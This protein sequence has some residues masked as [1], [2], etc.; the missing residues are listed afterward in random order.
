MF[1]LIHIISL[2]FI[3]IA[4]HAP[5][6]KKNKRYTILDTTIALDQYISQYQDS[7]VQS[8]NTINTLFEMAGH[9]A[10]INQNDSAFKYLKWAT[11]LDTDAL[12]FNYG[13]LYTLMQDKR[14]NTIEQTTFN[15]ALPKYKVNDT[16]TV[17]A[18]WRI[19]LIDQCYYTVI[20]FYE[21]KYSPEY[22]GHDSLWQL[23]LKAIQPNIQ[24]VTHLIDKIG[25]PKRS[26][27]TKK[28]SKAVFYALQHSNDS[29]ISHYLP[30]LAAACQ[31][32]EADWDDYAHMVD[33]ILVFNNHEQIYGTHYAYKSDTTNTVYLMPTKDTINLDKKRKILGLKPIKIHYKT[34]KIRFQSSKKK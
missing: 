28:G 12:L 10:I 7:L 18:L 17:K 14:W 11:E 20:H 4:C 31:A 27:Y 2:L 32:K 8:T 22:S 9:Y 1:K 33:R 23:R 6:N 29:I 3:L 30:L 25:W 19:K 34:Q 24:Y 26:E 5:I 13:D 16:N 21:R 15:K